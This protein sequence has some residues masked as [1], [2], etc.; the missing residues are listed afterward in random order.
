MTRSPP[1]DVPAEEDRRI[2]VAGDPRHQL[3]DP[4]DDRGQ[5][6]D[7]VQPVGGRVE[8]LAIAGEIADRAHRVAPDDQRPDVRRATQPLGEDL[9]PDVEPDRDAAAVQRPAVARVDDG[10]AAGRDDAPHVRPDVGRAEVV[11]G[12][13]LERPERRLAALGEDLRDRLAGGLLDRVVEVDERRPVA[14]GEP[15]PDGALAAAREPDE[16]D[17][18]RSPR[19]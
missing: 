1:S 5:L 19:A 13:A 12:L 2:G 15:P 7:A 4:L 17:V 6:G 14:M 18:H 9:G 16:D 10:A 8:P 3:V 11:D